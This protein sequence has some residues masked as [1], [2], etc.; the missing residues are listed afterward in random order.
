MFSAGK[1]VSLRPVA[2]FGRIG[3]SSRA[4]GSSPVFRPGRPAPCWPAWPIASPE[5]IRRRPAARY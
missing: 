2:R 4:A 5:T 1:R 3:R